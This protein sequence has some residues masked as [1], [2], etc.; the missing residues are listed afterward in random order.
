MIGIRL[1]S[2]LRILITIEWSHMTIHT[3]LTP[4]VTVFTPASI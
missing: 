2:W 3:A 1:F 4:T